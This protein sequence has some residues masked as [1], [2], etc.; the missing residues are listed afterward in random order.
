MSAGFRSDSEAP[1]RSVGSLSP[2]PRYDHPMNIEEDEDGLPRFSST[3][4]VL[5]DR[6][7]QNATDMFE[8]STQPPKSLGKQ[9]RPLTQPDLLSHKKIWSVKL[10]NST[11]KTG[12]ADD[13]GF[14]YGPLDPPETS[15]KK[16]GKKKRVLLLPNSIATRSPSIAARSPSVAARSPSI[17]AHS[18]LI[19]P[20]SPLI[21]DSV[22]RKKRK[23]SMKGKELAVDSADEPIYDA[24]QFLGPPTKKRKSLLQGYEVALNS[25]GDQ[26]HDSDQT[27]GHPRS[28]GK[29]N[30]AEKN[31]SSRKKRRAS[32]PL[33]DVGN[34]S[35]P[36]S[37][38]GSHESPLT[39]RHQRRRQDLPEQPIETASNSL[40]A[41]PLKSVPS[42][43]EEEEQIKSELA[44]T[45]SRVSKSDAGR[46]VDLNDVDD[47]G[48]HPLPMEA[49]PELATT[50]ASQL[51][52]SAND[53][54]DSGDEAQSNTPT[55]TIPLF[56]AATSA[57]SHEDDQEIPTSS[58]K[59]PGSRRKTKRKRKTPFFC[60]DDSDD[61]KENSNAS[62]ELPPDEAIV[63][64]V[65]SR[66]KKPRIHLTVDTPPRKPQ[67]R[68]ERK[69]QT[70][71]EQ[72]SQT[73]SGALS[74]AEAARVTTAVEAVRDINGLTQVAMNDIIH[75]NIKSTTSNKPVHQQLWE[76]VMGA[77]PS[78][79]RRKLIK[80][81]RQQFHN[82]VAR[83]TWTPDQDEE[84]LG[85]IK[86]HGTKWTKLG[87]MINRY[88]L[89]I[90]DRYR[91]YLVCHGFARTDF[92]S[93]QEEERLEDAVYEAIRQIQK[94]LAD[95]PTTPNDPVSL[96]NWQKISEAMGRTRTRL[97]CRE[98]WK[99]LR[100][101][102]GN[103]ITGFESGTNW[104]SGKARRDLKKITRRQK[105]DLFH[106]IRDSGVVKDSKIPW[107]EIVDETFR[108]EFERQALL[109]A[110]G[111]LRQAV[112][113]SG[114]KTT[115][116]C[117]THL[118]AL[119]ESG[120]GL[121]GDK[122][123]SSGPL[124]TPVKGKAKKGEKTAWSPAKASTRP[125]AKPPAE[126]RRNAKR[127]RDVRSSPPASEI[128]ESANE[129]DVEMRD[130]AS[131]QSVSNLFNDAAQDGESKNQFERE[132]SIDLGTDPQPIKRRTKAAKITYGKRNGEVVLGKRR[133]GES[134]YDS[135]TGGGAKKRKAQ[136]ITE[137]SGG[138]EDEG[139]NVVESSSIVSSDVSDMHD[140][141]PSRLFVAGDA[142]TKKG[143]RRATRSSA[144]R[145]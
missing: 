43:V 20:D 85:L 118:S 98:K 124:E 10:H 16:K 1:G 31:P 66:A 114:S 105:L 79:P 110:W 134:P 7:T 51:L 120:G 21:T 128:E 34:F 100:A 145:L 32:P 99:R 8:S 57:P 141:I 17:T 123:G 143:Q 30:R 97:Q 13:I 63:K 112:P 54:S 28:L 40:R 76:C 19:P 53:D 94:D 122:A 87:S 3:M 48:D 92:W 101:N 84:L 45:E 93:E 106:A 83:A 23:R 116:E 27:P 121:D 15:G 39:I 18:P 104:R 11:N 130:D 55:V 135:D 35:G 47:D 52:T 65:K 139:D 108:G 5:G 29:K 56:S 80:W 37:P 91:N 14:P 95:N 25:A 38:G 6:G 72:K 33:H 22:G 109:V 60:R 67:T 81:C 125:Q 59:T 9:S 2:L 44:E 74:P 71:S 96:V 144:R 113:E 24:Q 119:Y 62:A 4:P 111:R 46:S 142:N 58:A 50:E 42:V 115:F 41:A 140:I 36:E 138:G 78:L 107:K 137:A 129:E 77:C 126:T 86:I 127:G 68:S 133:R 90:R 88:P 132:V 49:S 26:T 75:S 69:P 136:A 64:P 82:F 103:N 12:N 61:D 131:P 73:R 70:Q 117:A 102:N 89:D